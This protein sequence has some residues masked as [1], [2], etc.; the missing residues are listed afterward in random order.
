[1]IV[2]RG[3]L[4][5]VELVAMHGE[6]S[7][8]E[9]FGHRMATLQAK[10]CFHIRFQVGHKPRELPTQRIGAEARHHACMHACML[11]QRVKVSMALGP[12]GDGESMPNDHGASH[13]S[14]CMPHVRIYLDELAF[15]VLISSS[16]TRPSTSCSA[17]QALTLSI[18]RS[19]PSPPSMTSSKFRR[20]KLLR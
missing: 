7:S 6:T 16:A 12:A 1:M 4:V 11:M 2:C 9:L 8:I 18:T 17:I 19:R 5:R 3:R 14:R 10:S 20:S 15:F 13:P